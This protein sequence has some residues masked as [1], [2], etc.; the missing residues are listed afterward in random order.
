[1]TT[2]AETA[3]CAHKLEGSDGLH[4]WIDG[5]GKITAGNGTLEQPKPNAFSLVQIADCPGA[6]SVCKASCYVHNLEKHAADTHALYKHNS[7]TIRLIL[8][9][10]GQSMDSPTQWARRMGTWIAQNCEGG[11]RWHVSGDV[12]SMR[13]ANWIAQVCDASPNVR[14]WIYTRSF[15]F[16]KPLLDCANLTVNLSCD[17]E[18]YDA[19]YALYEAGDP[20]RLCYLSHDG[21]VPTN[22]PPDSVIFPD[23]EFRGGTPLGDGWWSLLLPHEKKM[24]CPVDFHGKAENRRCGPCDKCIKEPI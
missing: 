15:R 7:Q 1:M 3:F 14:H 23:Y 19:A 22:L 9:P 17:A 10:T 6:T 20:I 5:N 24:V 16:L 11:F 4:L 21:R 8:N 12:F 2:A 18:N 13:Y